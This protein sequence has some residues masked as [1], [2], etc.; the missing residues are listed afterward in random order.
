MEILTKL[1]EEINSLLDTRQR[2]E[3]AICDGVLLSSHTLLNCS[4][5]FCKFCLISSVRIASEEVD[6][7]PLKC[8]GY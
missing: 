8:P 1:E 4:H 3:C 7:Y 2:G 6:K 5:T